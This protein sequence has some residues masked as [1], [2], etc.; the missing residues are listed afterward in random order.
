MCISILSGPAATCSLHSFQA[1][2]HMYL[3]SSAT[4]P[5]FHLS[6]S[7]HPQIFTMCL[8]RYGMVLIKFRLFDLTFPYLYGSVFFILWLWDELTIQPPVIE[9]QSRTPLREWYSFGSIA[10]I[11]GNEAHPAHKCTNFGIIL[12]YLLHK[13]SPC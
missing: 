13:L 5:F 8:N 6:L 1:C 12:C 11:S 3:H 9:F 4:S 2:C 10:D 7:S